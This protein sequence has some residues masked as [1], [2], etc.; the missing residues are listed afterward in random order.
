MNRPQAACSVLHIA[1]YSALRRQNWA[2]T[3]VAVTD[4]HLLL[5][6]CSTSQTRLKYYHAKKKQ[7]ELGVHGFKTNKNYCVCKPKQREILHIM[8]TALDE[9]DGRRGFRQHD[10]L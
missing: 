7:K 10:M 8:E 1:L 2:G 4:Q 3:V 5:L 6:V 9:L